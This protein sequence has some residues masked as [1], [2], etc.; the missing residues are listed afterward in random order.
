MPSL[1]AE[2]AAARINSMMP[3]QPSRVVV[4]SP[5]RAVPTNY[6]PQQQ[7][8]TPGPRPI[9]QQVPP[10]QQ[11]A[12]GSHGTD[13]AAVEQRAFADPANQPKQEPDNV[14]L[15]WWMR[16]AQIAG[17]AAAPAGVIDTG[18]RGIE[19]GMS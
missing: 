15:P 18:R 12:E 17:F 9:S 3:R 7:V 16:L 4:Y 5:G 2:L 1:L 10:W 13:W 11:R 6:V 19:L 14:K 8:Q